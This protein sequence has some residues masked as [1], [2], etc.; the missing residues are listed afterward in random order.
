M[1]ANEVA[2]HTNQLFNRS[3]VINGNLINESQSRPR[4]LRVAIFAKE[5]AIQL[6]FCFVIK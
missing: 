1:N 4:R 5:S 6:M 2:N 3:F